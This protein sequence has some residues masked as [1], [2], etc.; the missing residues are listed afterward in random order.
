M[1]SVLAFAILTA[2]PTSNSLPECS[3]T[4][5]SR[6][7]AN[8]RTAENGPLRTAADDKKYR[9][10][11]RRAA[12]GL[13]S[14]T[15]NCYGHMAGF[16]RQIYQK[17]LTIA[18]LHALEVKLV[19]FRIRANANPQCSRFAA[20]WARDSIVNAFRGLAAA[21]P[22]PD[23]PIDA[24]HVKSLLVAEAHQF[25]LSPE[26]LRTPTPTLAS[27][28]RYNGLPDSAASTTRTE[29]RTIFADSQ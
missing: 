14:I 16:E 17:S 7:A 27:V 21:A 23:G 22:L 6:I 10:Y 26:S 4:A 24:G 12:I 11:L 2:L 3:R 8:L 15:P 25:D 1:I 9:L 29:C 18:W 5:F 13:E 28:M 19:L 20:N